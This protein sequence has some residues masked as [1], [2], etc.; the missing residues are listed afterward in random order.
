MFTKILVPVD[1]T[2]SN[3]A[4]IEVASQLAASEDGSVTLLHVIE[5][6]ADAEFEDMKEFY[7]R[8]EEKARKA[9]VDLAAPLTVTG[10][11]VDQQI[12]Y[13]NRA[14]EIVGYADQHG[15]DLIV[16]S[17]RQLDPER[18]EKTWTSISHQV[19]V[20]ARCPVLLVK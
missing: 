4:A 15:T 8:L 9:M 18:P 7:Q 14:R 19:A 1:L 3:R 12:T 11:T 10:R 17:S 16:L 5:A 13:G 20:L 2:D 6:I